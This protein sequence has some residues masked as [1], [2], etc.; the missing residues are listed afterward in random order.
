MNVMYKIQ[1]MVESELELISKKPEM[2]SSDI[3]ATYKLIDI[4]KDITTIEAMQD[5]GYS[6]E[7]SYD[8][9]SMR[10]SGRG[11]SYRRGRDSMGRYTS[12]DS[13]YRDGYSGHN[14]SSMI[15]DLRELMDDAKNDMERDSIRRVIDIL[16]K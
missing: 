13:S 6:Q 12:R 11:N 1:D 7:G 15:E 14:K 5:S 9:M 16:N 2:S 4:L 8:D 3:E 10:Y